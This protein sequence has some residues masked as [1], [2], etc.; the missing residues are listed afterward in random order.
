VSRLLAK[1]RKQLVHAS[2]VEIEGK[3]YL[4]PATSGFGKTFL[5]LVLLNNGHQLLADDKT[6][7]DLTRTLIFPYSRRLRVDRRSALLFP[8]L[9]PFLRSAQRHFLNYKAKYFI[10]AEKAWPGSQGSV[11]PLSC[12]VFPTIWVDKLSKIIPCK[13]EHALSRILTS[14]KLFSQ[15]VTR[16][17][18]QA[19]FELATKVPSYHLLIGTDI[20]GVEKA[21][22]AGIKL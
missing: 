20:S 14:M 11:C 2:S 17:E 3:G 1:E 21:M 18:T 10:D 13:T 22:K 6:F 12:I 19:A 15:E 16:R 5:T 8:V 9:R 7:I 4:F